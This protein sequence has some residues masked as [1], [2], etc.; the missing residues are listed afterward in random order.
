MDKLKDL[1]EQR[2]KLEER[3]KQLE[4]E[5]K[6]PLTNDSE[7]NAVEEDNR[8]V[9]YSLYQVEKENLARVDADINETK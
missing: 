4:N 1:I 8:E 6:K 7:E 3:I 9:L 5:L 2:Q